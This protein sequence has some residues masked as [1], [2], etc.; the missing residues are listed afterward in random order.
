M[1]AL[2]L[3]S[4]KPTFVVAFSIPFSVLFALIIMYFTGININVM[5]LAGLCISIGMLV[6]NSVV[7]ME[8]IFRLR[9]KGIPAPRAAVQGTKQVAAPIVASTATTI[10]VFL[11]MVY[12]TGMVAQLMIPFAFTISYALAASLIVALT[13]VPTLGSIILKKTKE[14]KHNWFDK[15]KNLYGKSLGFSLR[16]KYIPI[17]VS[18]LLLG[19][20]IFQ[21]FGTGM[22]MID[23][24]ESNQISATLQLGNDVTKKKAFKTA[25]KVLDAIMK[26]KGVSK[27]SALD[28]NTGLMTS[29]MGSS[30]SEDFSM[31]SF[32]I[33]TD[34]NIKTTEEYKRIRKRNREEYKGY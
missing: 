2:F 15:L 7:V 6:D 29:I 12:T 10:C 21:M 25:D 17:I 9:Q 34:D 5:S 13:V 4:V 8:N 11:P 18:V 20:C 31:F 33:L 26:V 30:V 19:I 22:T 24:S 14:R 16:H 3:K 23:S 28:G 1:L 27:V 32:N